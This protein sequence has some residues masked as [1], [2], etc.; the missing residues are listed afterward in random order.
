VEVLAEV[1]AI[2]P[3]KGVE[4]QASAAAHLIVLR[5]HRYAVNG[6]TARPLTNPTETR[7][8]ASAQVLQ[9]AQVG[10]QFVPSMAIVN[11][12]ATNRKERKEELQA[13][14]MVKAKA[15]EILAEGRH[16]IVWLGVEPKEVN[17]VILA[18]R[19]NVEALLIAQH[20]H[21]FVVNGITAKPKSIQMEI[22]MLEN[23]VVQQIVQLGHQFAH[24][25]AIVN[26]QVMQVQM[27]E[28]KEV[29]DHNQD[30][31][32]EV[33]LVEKEVRVIKRVEAMGGG[34]QEVDRMVVGDQEVEGHQ[35][36]GLVVEDQEE[37]GLVEEDQEVE[38]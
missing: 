30:L 24:P 6:A 16:Q 36:E 38:D 34:N 12:L 10:H 25:M 28:L 26:L 21:Q 31:Q 20:M 29:L 4:I 17:W 15:M 32:E 19:V 7:M 18:T 35:V 37:A 11:W 2:S 23:V 5:G 3:T 14:H 1:E 9:T 8:L 27:G 33:V 13:N 22:P